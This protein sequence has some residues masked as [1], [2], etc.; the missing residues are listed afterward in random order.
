MCVCVC[1][2][3]CVRTSTKTKSTFEVKENLKLIFKP[4]RGVPFTALELTDKDL[5]R[6]E[7]L[8]VISKIDYSEWASPTVYI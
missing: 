2:C 5:N 1:V 6:V 4:K 3:V 8:R 7:K